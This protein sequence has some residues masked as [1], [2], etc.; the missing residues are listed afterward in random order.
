MA[1]YTTRADLRSLAASI[2]E[3][4]ATTMRKSAHNRSPQGATFLSHSTKDEKLVIGAISLLNIHG[5]SVYVDK[6]DP[7]LPPYTNKETASTLR[8]RIGQAGKFVLLAST[9]SQES[10]WVPWELGLADGRKSMS[11]IALFPVV[12]SV[13]ETS[14]TS[15]EY[16]GLY[17]RIVYGKLKNYKKNVWMV[18][19]S[20][21]NTATELSAWLKA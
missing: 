20:E 10:K 14:W 12:D 19:K 9:N 17:D 21:K 8:T 13:H 16:L 7:A 6:K 1:V 11:Q 2:N 4:T 5:A 18:L 15:S 3:D